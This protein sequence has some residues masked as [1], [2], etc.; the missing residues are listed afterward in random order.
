MR[1]EALKWENKRLTE[2]K[3]QLEAQLRDQS[4]RLAQMED[5]VAELK[6]CGSQRSAPAR[7]LH[8]SFKVDI[9]LLI[10]ERWPSQTNP[11]LSLDARLSPSHAAHLHYALY[12]RVRIHSR[13]LLFTHVDGI[14]MCCT[15]EG[16]YSKPGSPV[17]KALHD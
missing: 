10:F 11:S 3:A 4:R 16:V 14:S 17:Q 8:R 15:M 12:K 7:G 2:A 9:I 1:A 5:A 6:G 13:L